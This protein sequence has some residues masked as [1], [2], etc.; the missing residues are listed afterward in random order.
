MCLRV[1]LGVPKLL[2]ESLCHCVSIAWHQG[3]PAAHMASLGV[4]KLLL[5]S[6]CL[7]SVSPGV[8]STSHGITRVPNVSRGVTGGP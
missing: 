8:P 2:L 7:H 1:S 3:P 5:G 6:L 4:P